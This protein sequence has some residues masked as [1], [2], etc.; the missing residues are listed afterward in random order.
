M[1]FESRNNQQHLQKF[2]KDVNMRAEVKQTD[3]R[4]VYST[5]YRTKR[6]FKPVKKQITVQ[7]VL[8][9]LYTVQYF[10]EYFIYEYE[11]YYTYLIFLGYFMS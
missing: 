9:L 4:S 8:S 2:L 3:F 1:T 11:L 6:T 5:A 10:T 7:P